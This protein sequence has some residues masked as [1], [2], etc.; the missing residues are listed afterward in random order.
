MSSSQHAS[1][2]DLA[3]AENADAAAKALN[4]FAGAVVLPTGC[5]ETYASRTDAWSKPIIRAFGLLWQP[6]CLI[7]FQR[8]QGV[9]ASAIFGDHV[10]L[11]EGV[12]VGPAR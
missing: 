7:R 2:S 1:P 3:F 8:R 11:G 6:S 4:S 12:S 5:I 9:H 10:E